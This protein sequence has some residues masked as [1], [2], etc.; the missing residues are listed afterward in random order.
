MAVARVVKVALIQVDERRARPA[1]GRQHPIDALTS[2]RVVGDR[3]IVGAAQ[4]GTG[5][6]AV[7]EQGASHAARPHPHVVEPLE[8]RR[9]GLEFLGHRIIGTPLQCVEHPLPGRGAE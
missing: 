1:R 6:A 7:G 3:D 2:P 8:P 9:M 5:Q 4:S